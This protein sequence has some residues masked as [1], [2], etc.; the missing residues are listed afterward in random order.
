MANAVA[1]DNSTSNDFLNSEHEHSFDTVQAAYDLWARLNIAHTHRNTINAFGNLEQR[2]HRNVDRFEEYVQAYFSQNAL[3]EPSENTTATMQTEIIGRLL[4]NF[5]SSEPRDLKM[6]NDQVKDLQPLAGNRM[7]KKLQDFITMYE[8]WQSK[9]ISRMLNRPH[10]ATSHL[11]GRI[12]LLQL[13]IQEIIALFFGQLEKKDAEVHQLRRENG[14]L[15]TQVNEMESVNVL[16]AKHALAL[17]DLEARYTMDLKVLEDQHTDHMDAIVNAKVR[18]VSELSEK[19]SVMGLRYNVE[20]DEA[21]DFHIDAGYPDSETK[22]TGSDHIDDFEAWSKVPSDDDHNDDNWV[23]GLLKAS[24]HDVL[25]PIIRLKDE[26]RHSL[27][28][29]VVGSS[30]YYGSMSSSPGATQ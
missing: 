14:D 7:Q 9:P 17:K 25:V 8:A 27:T 20:V 30:Q 28:G 2:S 5:E 24:R 10:D 21:E 4:E 6:L 29:T 19:L 15:R 3:D 18:E 11:L 1:Q 13:N 22:E 23:R 12:R 16:E 26:S